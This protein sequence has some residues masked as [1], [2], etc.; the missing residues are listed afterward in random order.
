MDS[1]KIVFSPVTLW[2]NFDATLPSLETETVVEFEN[3]GIQLTYLYF[4]GPSYDDGVSR[5]YGVF[6][7]RKGK[8]NLPAIVLLGHIGEPISE[9]EAMFW[10][11]KGYAVLAFDNMG[12]TESGGKHTI[13]P[14]S[15]EYANYS[16]SGRHLR[17]CDTNAKETCWYHWAAN[18]RRA[19][20]FVAAQ[21]CVDTSSIGL[22]ASGDAAVT[23]CMAAAFD[24]RLS[25]CAV[26]FGVCY[27]D[28]EIVEGQ[29][30]E[31]IE[32]AEER[33]RWFAGI[34]PQSYLMHM[35]T[36]FFLCISANSARTD[37]DKTYDALNLIPKETPWALWITDK[38]PGTVGE[39]FVKNL[40]RW[41]TLR[42]KKQI[43]NALLPVV[44]FRVLG[45]RLNL[46]VRVPDEEETQDVNVFFAREADEN[47]VRN[48]NKINLEKIADG[49]YRAVVDV[50]DKTQPCY[51]YCNVRYK[52]GLILSGNLI[53]VGPEKLVNVA[54]SKKTKII[55]NGQMGIGNFQ[56]YSP[57]DDDELHIYDDEK[58]EV[59]QGPYDIKG[60]C[61]KKFATFALNDSKYIKNDDGILA[62]DVYSK[63]PQEMTVSVVVDYGE[64]QKVYGVTEKLIGGELWQKVCVS[65]SELKGERGRVPGSWSLCEVLCFEAEKEIIINNVI[66]N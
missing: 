48:W 66:L 18:T 56:I 25:A 57:T 63:E 36:P 19:V 47:S 8:K 13:Y 54:E 20:T 12:E 5:I 27:Q 43:D 37:L 45:G 38:L 29:T 26:L 6:A 21:E 62:F 23:A 52:G 10:A 30:R 49:I 51:A 32:K 24:G 65:L 55:Y 4:N 41:L 22:L 28:I 15:V 9:R 61:G 64:G 39:N 53:E 35:H 17:Y 42:L 59:K 58:L 60:I 2:R 50:Y 46:I 33:E 31:Q 40:D 16:K 14:K 11:K 7:R 34:A 3:D 1:R 44:D